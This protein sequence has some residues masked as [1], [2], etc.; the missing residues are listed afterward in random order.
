SS[1]LSLLHLIL[2]TLAIFGIL[3]SIIPSKKSDN[4][5]EMF[6]KKMK[7]FAILGGGVIGFILS[8]IPI[9]FMILTIFISVLIFGAIIE[10]FIS[11]QEKRENISIKWRFYS[12]IFFIIILIM[13][14]ILLI[15]QFF[16]L[17]F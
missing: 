2:I 14:I 3:Y 6:S 7:R 8:F 9:E 11:Y 17:L 15:L 10:T 13:T 16:N 1:L 4:P 12:I 5:D